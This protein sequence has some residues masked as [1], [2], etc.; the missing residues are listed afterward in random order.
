MRLRSRPG[1]ALLSVLAQRCADLDRRL[2]SACGYSG[3]LERVVTG[4][5]LDNSRLRSNLRAGAEAH[6]ALERSHLA[7]VALERCGQGAVEGVEE[8]NKGG[9][10]RHEQ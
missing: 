1:E 2:S 7:L 4:L 5:R 10:H 3:M 6:A 8:E 9:Q